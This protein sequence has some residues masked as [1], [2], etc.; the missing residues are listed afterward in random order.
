[1]GFTRLGKSKIGLNFGFLS[2]EGEW[3]LTDKQ[4]EAAWEMYV[5]LVTRISVV[6][7]KD[8]EGLLREALTSLYSLFGTTREILRKYGPEIAKAPG[9]STDP[10][11]G[12]L[13]VALLN[14]VIRPV[15]AKWHPMLKDY[16]DQRPQGTSVTNHERAWEKSTELRKSLNDVRLQIVEYANVLAEVAE[17]SPLV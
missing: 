8:D 7:L 3:D 16:E 12:H 10:T 17:V 13:A 11:F 14:K 2:I 1:M 6:E 9:K 5:E 15:L 4:R